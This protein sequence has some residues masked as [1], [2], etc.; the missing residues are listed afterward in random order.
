M[1]NGMRQKF[2]FEYEEVRPA[3]EAL[4]S[5]FRIRAVPLKPVKIEITSEKNLIIYAEDMDGNKYMVIFKK[6]GEMIR[7]L[8]TVVR[9]AKEG[10]M[11]G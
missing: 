5:A 7:K 9:V 11:V 4:E 1:V 3:V 6:S 10:G 8:W 2:L